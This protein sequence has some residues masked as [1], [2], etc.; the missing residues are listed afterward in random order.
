VVEATVRVTIVLSE[1]SVE[2]HAMRRL[3]DLKLTRERSPIFALSWTVMHVIDESSAIFGMNQEDLEERNA[4][5]IVTMNGWDLT[6]ASTVHA[7]QMYHLQDLQ[8]GGKF[9]D[10]ISTLDDGRI[11]R[12]MRRFHDIENV[13]SHRVTEPIAPPSPG[14][15]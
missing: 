9:V 5:F 6:Y 8:W 14:R 11:Q 1:V 12:D 13:G 7:R 4:L 3:H 10:V 15:I 2:G